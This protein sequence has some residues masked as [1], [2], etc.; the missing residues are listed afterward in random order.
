MEKSFPMEISGEKIRLKKNPSTLAPVVFA[1]VDENRGFL[2]EF[3]PWVDT[4]LSVADSWGWIELSHRQ[5][6]S[7]LMFD[8]GIYLGE[9]EQYIGNIGV[10][11]IDWGNR[12]CEIGFWIGAQFQGKG[13]VSQA[14]K[15]LQAVLFEKGFNRIE[16][17]CSQ[18]N[19]RSAAV[20]KRNGYL[21]D[22]VL[23]QKVRQN[24][25][26]SDLQIYSRLKSDKL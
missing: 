24:N 14:L 5:W 9:L 8:F 18:K 25:K 1:T 15:S 16:I 12:C 10:H 19:I 2:R 17:H 7:G 11:N 13:L 6:E 4:T 26:Y 22:G 20:A 23:R 21:L 3:L